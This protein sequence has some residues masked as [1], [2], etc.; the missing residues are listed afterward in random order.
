MKLI[1]VYVSLT[2]K[3]YT[4]ILHNPLTLLHMKTR[5]AQ[6]YLV[7]MYI[8]LTTTLHPDMYCLTHVLVNLYLMIIP[9]YLVSSVLI[10]LCLLVALIRKENP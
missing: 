7:R 6:L 8:K 10:H 2:M 1:G 5:S 3:P 4:A 9:F